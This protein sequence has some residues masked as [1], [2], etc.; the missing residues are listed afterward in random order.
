MTDGLAAEAEPLHH[1][2]VAC[3]TTEQAHDLQRRA[4]ALQAEG[5][6]DD[7]AQAAATA[8]AIAEASDPAS[9]DIANLLNDL[10]E[11]EID[12]QR[13]RVALDLTER[14]HAT[15]LR[16]GSALSGETA[17]RLQIKTFT[18][19]GT[20]RRMLGEAAAESNELVL[21]LET[22]ELAFGPCHDETT[23]ARNNLAVDYKAAG[24][25]DEALALYQ[26]S[27][28][29]ALRAHGN[30][31]SSLLSSLHH[32]LGGVH[33]AMGNFAAAEG[34]A[35][36]A[37]EMSA[38]LLG[39]D[40]PRTQMDSI[41]YAAI[42]DGLGR[43][44]AAQARYQAAEIVLL[45]VWGPAHA[46]LAALWHN[47]AASFAAQGQLDRALN[48]YR[49]ALQVKD[50]VFGESSPD[51]ALTRIGLAGVLNRQSA[52]GK[53]ERLLLQARRALEGRTAPDH[54]HRQVLQGH[55]A[56]ARARQAPT[57]R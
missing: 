2:G 39:D 54:P 15:L 30:N 56:T 11:I 4:W 50:R 13:H 51:A 41:A 28:R 46:E 22:A 34:S 40:D 48:H 27:L 24:R 43:H 23:A 5:L 45:R 44:A 17:A 49:R 33:H 53:A 57:T 1:H 55:L 37:W 29:H 32:N 52:F 9:A 14:A 35:R 7:A 8:L 38:Q 25:F 18:L 31:P 47:L 19:L 10:A 16:L 12:R 21:A 20:L 6:H 26:E 3:M 42:L 36:I